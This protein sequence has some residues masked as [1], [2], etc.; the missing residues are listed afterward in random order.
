MNHLYL[1]QKKVVKQKQFRASK[2]ASKTVFV[3]RF[4]CV[5]QARDH[6]VGSFDGH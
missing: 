6:E 5:R 4:F 2:N 1:N 3:F